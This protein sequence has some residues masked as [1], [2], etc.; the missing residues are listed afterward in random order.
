MSDWSLF[1]FR[2]AGRSARASRVLRL[3]RIFAR[4]REGA[5]YDEI[6]IEER[7]SVRRT[8]QIVAQWLK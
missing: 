6:A 4:L 3:R 8:R 7:L 1:P 5:S 2:R